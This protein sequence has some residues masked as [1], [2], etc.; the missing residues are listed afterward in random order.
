MPLAEISGL[1][2]NSNSHRVNRYS[3]RAAK[4]A[5]SKRQFLPI[6]FSFPCWQNPSRA[7]HNHTPQLSAQRAQSNTQLLGCFGAMPVATFERCHDQPSLHFVERNFIRRAKTFS[8][9]LWLAAFDS[10]AVSQPRPQLCR[11]NRRSL[12]EHASPRDDVLQF[13]DITGPVV[14][15]QKFASRRFERN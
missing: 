11:G 3:L 13:A 5:A 1:T 14:T 9:R 2:S 7:A 4:S 6:E 8:C 10:V 15:A 12:I